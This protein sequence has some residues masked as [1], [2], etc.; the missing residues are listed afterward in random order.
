MTNRKPKTVLY[1]RRR[2]QKTDYNKRLSLL[3]SRKS[4]LVVRLTNQRVI[5]QVVK[6]TTAGD[7]VVTAV[8]SFHLK[9]LGWS[10]S[11]KN[12]PAC[13]LTG[14]AIGKKALSKGEKEAI[15]DTAQTYPFKGGRI[16]AFLKGAVDS[17]L[18]IAYG[19]EEIFPSA[20]RISG[21]HLKRKGQADGIHEFADVKKK[22]MKGN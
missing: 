21:E 11:C 19:S 5:A 2:E 13:Y 9:E 22:I 3:K 20:A 15:L 7:L 16:L 4:R 12:I 8:D 6:F 14:L 17:G 18:A 1:R 10:G